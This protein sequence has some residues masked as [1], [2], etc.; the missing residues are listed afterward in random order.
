MLKIFKCT[1]YHLSTECARKIRD[2]NVKCI[3]RINT[4]KITKA[5]WHIL[6]PGKRN[7][8]H[9]TFTSLMTC[10]LKLNNTEAK[11]YPI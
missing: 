4:Q 3:N 11:V 8:N 6:L 1:R 10:V 9:I 5:A 7:T 2:E